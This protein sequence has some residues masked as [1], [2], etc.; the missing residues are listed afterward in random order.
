MR[1]GRKIFGAR[2][3]VCARA[4][5]LSIGFCPGM[6]AEL[7]P[8][9]VGVDVNVV[10]T[11][12]IIYA[13]YDWEWRLHGSGQHRTGYRQRQISRLLSISNLRLVCLVRSLFSSL[14]LMRFLR[15]GPGTTPDHLFFGA[16]RS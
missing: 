16:H 9:K 1:F 15:F 13:D 11:N 8:I 6:V 10:E 14:T 12:G 4:S 5:R 2:L 3:S 7:V